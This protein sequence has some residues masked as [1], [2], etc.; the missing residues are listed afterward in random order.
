[1]ARPLLFLDI[2]GV[3]N[4]SAFRRMHGRHVVDPILVAR[5]NEIL[6]RTGA[7]VVITS[8]WRIDLQLT[9]IV[10]VLV[11]AG[12]LMPICIIDVTP[13]LHTPRSGEIQRWI[14]RHPGFGP[15]AILDDDHLDGLSQLQVRTDWQDGLTDD[16]AEQAIALLC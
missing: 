10:Q 2:D 14:D 12:F 11:E 4:T 7:A 3:L 15:V 13:R 1:M 6:R 9:E 16:D 5:L 8:S